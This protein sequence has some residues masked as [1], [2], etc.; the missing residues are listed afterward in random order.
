MLTIKLLGPPAIERDG[1]A[2]RPPR[3]HKAWA[4]LSFVVLAD[5]PPSRRQLAEL[6]FS[7]ADDPLGALRWTLAELRRALGESQAL[8]GDP[9][10]SG[11]GDD[12]VIDVQLLDRDFIDPGA[13]LELDGEL[14]EGVDP[15]SREDFETWLSIERHRLSAMIEAR[16]RQAAI[17]LVSSGQAADAI[18]YAA[19]AVAYNQLEEGNHELLVRCL[20]ASGDVDGA[21]RQVAI[22]EDL[23]QRTL[24]LDASPALREAANTG[25]DSPLVPALS[26]RAAA[27]SQL[28]AGRAAIMAGA[29]DAGVQCL[30]RAVAEAA[31]SHD[32]A[33]HA[34]ALAALGSALV[35]AMRGR[36]EEG[37]V[38]LHEAI[39][40]ADRMGDRATTTTA[41]RELGYIEVAAG[42]RLTADRWLTKAEAIADTAE[43]RSAI[44][45]VRGMNASDHADYL[46]ALEHLEVS[47][48]L[49]R[50]AGQE[51]QLA[52]SLSILGRAHLLRGERRQAGL[53]LAESIRLVREQR[54]LA[55]LPWPQTLQAELDLD[56]GNVD[57]AADDLE[58]AWTLARQLCDPCWEGMA[59][60]GL[61]LLNAGRGDYAAATTWLAE[62]ATRSGR[63]PDRYQW[64]HAHVLDTMITTAIGRDDHE[65]ATALTTT[66]STLA[67][68]GD[69][70]EL[71]ARAYLHRYRLGDTTGL[72]AARM[73][74]SEIDNPRLAAL[75]TDAN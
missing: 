14:L 25:T 5:R 41:L 27:I 32:D 8:R 18:A 12:V 21:R 20:A 65:R 47:I 4:L 13:L 33:L 75:V 11:F 73:I 10:S 72:G 43:E 59:A 42:R 45:G 39:E 56:D 51:R 19:R 71:V 53:N 26:G 38:V 31:H 22:C 28:E 63:A 24:G 58:Q 55:F 54:W 48:E 61:G 29:V 7:E 69:M 67:A 62:A 50:S 60:R 2:L 64:V 17:A 52:W 34:H 46:G 9:I 57:R 30:R 1:R 66:L 70:R 3:G 35:H 23:L 44:L 40:L 36:D 74:A 15:N 49:A 68:R 6:L 16:L 37:A